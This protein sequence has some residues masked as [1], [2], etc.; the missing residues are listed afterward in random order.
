MSDT[1]FD[2]SESNW[3]DF[4]EENIWNEHQWRNYLKDSDKD[5]QRFLSIYN[6]LKEK[7]NHFD[8]IATRMGWDNEDIA[9]TEDM[10]LTDSEYDLE[11]DTDE[12]LAPYSPLSHPVIVVTHALYNSLRLIWENYINQEDNYISA[13]ICWQYA[14]SLHQAE[15]NVILAVHAIDLGDYGLTI[16]H[17]KN[18]LGALNKTLSLL[19]QI[20]HR[21]ENTVSEFRQETLI[22]L[23]DLRELWIRVMNDCRIEC[24]RRIDNESD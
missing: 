12:E 2:S 17:L 7:P 23:F 24:N 16:C 3:D 8:E 21:N 22:R 15:M 9:L 14:N 18:S 19:D 1:N 5:I 4:S 13:Q 10:N 20:D 6:T 11:E